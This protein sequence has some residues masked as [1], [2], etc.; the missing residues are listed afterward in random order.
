MALTPQQIA[1][2]AYRA[3]FRGAD[4]VKAVAIAMAESGGNPQAYNPELAAGTKSGAGSRGLWQVYGTAHPQ[5]NNATM[6]DPLENAK[7][8]Y[9]VYREAGN[10]FTPWSTWNLGMASK[11]IP[12][13]PKFKIDGSPAGR[14]QTTTRATAQMT[15]QTSDAVSNVN[16]SIGTQIKTGVDG[17]I[18]SVKNAIAGKTVEGKQREFFDIGIYGAG[19]V[20]I[21]IGLIFIFV[22]SDAGKQTIQL[23]GEGTKAVA[24]KGLSLAL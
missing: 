19:V 17:A 9:Q 12:T 16:N 24:T 11:L 21:L 15:G 6:F 1:Q 7:A 3:G 14:A 20:L 4:L 2:Y 10:K 8:A 13:L 23:A 5:F 22:N 18:D